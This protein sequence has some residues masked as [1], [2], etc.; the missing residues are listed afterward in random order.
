MKILHIRGRPSKNIQLETRRKL[1]FFFERG[2]SASFTAQEVGLNIKTVCK[3]FRKFSEQFRDLEDQNFFERTRID[4]E[5]M[6]LSYDSIISEY[7]DMVDDVNEQISKSKKDR[8][9]LIPNY[10]FQIKSNLLKKI[11]NLLEKKAGF[12]M[13]PPLDESLKKIIQENV[14]K[15][16]QLT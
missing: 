13:Q 11:S 15:Y 3:Y 2:Y 1:Q 10:L 6:I 4:R 12:R 8:E 16:G 5:R 14:E 9:R 7:Y